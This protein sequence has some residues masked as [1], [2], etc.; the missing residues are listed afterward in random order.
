MQRRT[1][2]NTQRF[3]S[4]ATAEHDN[5]SSRFWNNYQQL[6]KQIAVD[7]GDAAHVLDVGA[8]TGE[9]ALAVAENATAVDAVDLTPE[10]IE[11]GKNKAIQRGIENIKFTVQDA[12]ALDFK[13]NSFDAVIIANLLH[14][15]DKPEKV[16]LEINRVLIPGGLLVAPTFLHGETIV[17][18]FLSILSQIKGFPIYHRFSARRFA[19]LIDDSG[20]KVI[21]QT[22]RAGFIPMSYI[23]AKACDLSSRTD[24]K[25][26]G[27]TVH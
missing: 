27:F 24:I 6:V 23:V 11:A 21:T 17:S 15:I 26:C 3:W 8:G 14:V 12:S 1:K 10:M 9:M 25:P 2:K 20:F 5:H 18:L 7:V 13:D 16:L 22:R 4:K 19:R